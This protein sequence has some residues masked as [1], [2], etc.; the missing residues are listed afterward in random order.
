VVRNE[1]DAEILR[2]SLEANNSGDIPRLTT[3]QRSRWRASG[4]Q[5]PLLPEVSRSSSEA[6]DTWGSRGSV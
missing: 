6:F 4:L 5:H 2:T 3:A 1:L